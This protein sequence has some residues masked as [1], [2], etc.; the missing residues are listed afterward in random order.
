MKRKMVLLLCAVLCIGLIACG[1]KQAPAGKQEEKEEGKE[2]QPLLELELPLAEEKAELSVWTFYENSYVED[3]NTV[4]GVMEMEKQTNVHINWNTVTIQ[5]MTEKFGLL[6]ASGEYPDIIYNA[7]YPGGNEKAVAEGIYLELTDLMEFY[8]P[9][10]KGIITADDKL[11]KDVITDDG[12]VIGIYGVNCN[13]EG[14]AQ[15]N[16]WSGLTIRK[17]WLDDLGLSMPETIEEWHEVL[18][19]FKEQK[20]ATAPLTTGKNGYVKMGAF[21][22]AYDVFP[23]YYLDGDTVK[24]GPLEDGYR[25]WVQLFRDWYA[26]GL[27]DPDFTA[28]DFDWMADPTVSATG[29]A[30]AFTNLYSFTEDILFQYGYTQEEK[31]S[32]KPVANPVLN[33]G[34]TPKSLG[35]TS[36]LAG[37]PIFVSTQ[38]KNPELAVQWLDYQ[39]TE[40]GMRLNF[41]GVQDQ[42]YTITEDG[43]YAFTDLIMQNPDG[44]T[45]SDA[46]GL[47]ARGNGLGMYNWEAQN[48]TQV[49]AERFIANQEV[50]NA[51]DFS[52]VYPQNASLTE[53]E[54]NTY[55]SLYTNVETMVNE[56]TVQFIIGAKAMEE[57]D[58]FLEKLKSFGAEECLAVKQAAYDRYQNRSLK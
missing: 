13:D 2:K 8:M 17:D 20:G 50:W 29:K 9:N 41:Y 14:P 31:I 25:E 32:V 4:P 45:P 56:N 24:Y 51:Q 48:R 5:E 54:G 23:G 37:N 33:K 42:S 43:S 57:Y 6:L 53:E 3:L 52:Q 39:F 38:C 40:D 47:Y 35:V 55:N 18:V 27:I 30:G 22:S 21:M 28:N 46:L 1:K 36:G 34:E 11:L 58:S 26:E 7:A 44:H 10:Y 49:G 16:E 19:A 15:E 12:R